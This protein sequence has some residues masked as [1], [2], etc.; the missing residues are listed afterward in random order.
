M[1]QNYTRIISPNVEPFS[2]LRSRDNR[3]DDLLKLNTTLFK[4]RNTNLL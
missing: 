4:R 3:L 2:G 1:F